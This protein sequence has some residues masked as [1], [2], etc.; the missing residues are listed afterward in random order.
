MDLTEFGELEVSV[1]GIHG[2]WH[3]TLSN[4]V[5]GVAL[6]VIGVSDRGSV[7]GVKG[8]VNVIYIE[9]STRAGTPIVQEREEPPVQT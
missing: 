1:T 3:A 4:G 8:C 2:T 7:R 6:R 5:I 9:P